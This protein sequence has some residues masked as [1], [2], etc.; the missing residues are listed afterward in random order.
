MKRTGILL[1]I[2]SLL[3]PLGVAAEDVSVL[4]ISQKVADRGLKYVDLGD[5]KGSVYLHGLAELAL[6]T[7]D[8]YHETLVTSIL[9]E[10]VA[11]KRKGRGNFIN[12]L[13]GG[14]ALAELNYHG[15]SQYAE[16]ASRAAAHM[17]DEQKK[18]PSGHMVPPWKYID[19]KDPVFVDILLAVTPFYLYQGLKEN[20]TDYVDYAVWM[21]KD[22]LTVLQDKDTGLY[23]QARG[24]KKLDEGEI[25]KDCWSRGNGWASIAYSAL[26]HDLPSSHPEYR[27]ICKMARKFFA[28][29]S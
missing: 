5:Y 22:I 20:R 9:D 6:V 4:E 8:K 26:L 21:L 2:I 12:Y 24:V 3:L 16:S 10:F 7:G 1:C 13:Y 18:N 15:Y 25:S 19:E 23:H 28:Q 29:S 17:W 11:G 14:A 27:T